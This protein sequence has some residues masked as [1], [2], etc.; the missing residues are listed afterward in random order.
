MDGDILY[1]ILLIIGAIVSIVRRA[2]K[3]NDKKKAPAPRTSSPGTGQQ[4]KQKQSV[5]DIIAEILEAQQAKKADQVQPKPKPKPKPQPKPQPTYQTYEQKYQPLERYSN[6]Q[7]LGPSY[8]E[9][10]YEDHTILHSLDHI[11]DHYN[12]PPKKRKQA[13]KRIAAL[14]NKP[15][16]MREAIIMSEILNRKYE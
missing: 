13:K 12:D 7:E 1:I 8:E 14:G 9:G 2:N 5:E 6:D 4:P 11:K 3:G 10:S 15:F 16:N